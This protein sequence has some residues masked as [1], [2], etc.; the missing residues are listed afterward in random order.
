MLKP[1]TLSAFACLF[2]WQANAQTL[3]MP[4]D[5]QKAFDNGTRSMDGKPGKNYWQTHGV[6]NIAVTVAPPDRTV[7]GVEKIT[8]TNNSPDELKNLNMKLI[9]NVHAAG[10]RRG[11]EPNPAAAVKV[12]EIKVDGKSIAWDNEKAITTNQMIDLPKPLKSKG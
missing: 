9:V 10:G 3:T 11:G 7:K 1:L 4:A 5:V 2:F 8:Y 6:Y 12:D